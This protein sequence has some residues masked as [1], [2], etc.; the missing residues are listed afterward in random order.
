MYD[1]AAEFL[2][3]AQQAGGDVSHLELARCY[4]QLGRREDAAREFRQAITHQEAPKDYLQLCVQ[5]VT[6]NQASPASQ[7]DTEILPDS[8]D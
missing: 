3:E 5:A 7:P 6:T 4:W 2:E 1:W 8:Q